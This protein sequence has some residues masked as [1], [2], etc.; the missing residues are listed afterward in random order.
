MNG[1][2]VKVKEGVQRSVIGDRSVVEDR[3]VGTT[4]CGR[5]LARSCQANH[6]EVEGDFVLQVRGGKHGS[7]RFVTEVDAGPGRRGR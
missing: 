5:R 1:R 3:Q 2:S 7:R 4:T 6:K